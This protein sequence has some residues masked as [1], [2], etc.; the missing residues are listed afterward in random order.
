MF[1]LFSPILYMC[2]LRIM[3]SKGWGAVEYKPDSM[4]NFKSYLPGPV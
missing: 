3:E 4:I 1:G 2:V